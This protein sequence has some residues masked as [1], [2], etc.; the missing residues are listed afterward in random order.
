MKKIITCVQRNCIFLISFYLEKKNMIANFSQGAT[1]TNGLGYL[2]IEQ[3][4]SVEMQTFLNNQ[5]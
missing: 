4:H 3:C 5:I 1:T 2:V